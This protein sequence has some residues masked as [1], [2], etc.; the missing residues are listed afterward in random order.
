MGWHF[1]WLKELVWL[2]T[3]I[4]NR[5]VCFEVSEDLD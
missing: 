2:G 5:N 3:S 4:L 1:S